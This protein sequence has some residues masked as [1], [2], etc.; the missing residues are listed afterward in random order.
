MNDAMETLIKQFDKQLTIEQLDYLRFLYEN[1]HI[2]ELSEGEQ[3]YFID[4][5]FKSEPLRN[6]AAFALE[7]TDIMH[8]IQEN[9]P[10]IEQAERLAN[11]KEQR[12]YYERK[13]SEL[14]RQKLKQQTTKAEIF[15]MYPFMII[16]KTLVR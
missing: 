5:F 8:E 2:E 10:A 9:I 13:W 14:R 11:G 16:N 4:Y 3:H 1:L 6:M 12:Q 7:L 15:T